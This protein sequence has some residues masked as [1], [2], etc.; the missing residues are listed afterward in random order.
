[1]SVLREEK[2]ARSEHQRDE[3]GSASDVFIGLTGSHSFRLQ[4]VATPKFNVSG[5]AHG[6][7]RRSLSAN[8]RVHVLILVKSSGKAGPQ[9]CAPEHHIEREAA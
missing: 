1:M 7:F 9:L 6:I 8:S 3:G 5:R 2:N 4:H